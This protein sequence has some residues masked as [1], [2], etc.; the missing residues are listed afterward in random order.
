MKLVC[1]AQTLAHQWWFF[2]CV[3]AAVI[4]KC[5]HNPMLHAHGIMKLEVCEDAQRKKKKK[6]ECSMS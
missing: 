3:V 1:S 2:C 6:R 5:L 4:T